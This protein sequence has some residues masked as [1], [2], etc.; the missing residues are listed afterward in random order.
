LRL[1]PKELGGLIDR[2][3]RRRWGWLCETLKHD[4]HRPH[5]D[6][7]D[8]LG[9]QDEPDERFAHRP[10]SF[11]EH[12]G[13]RGESIGNSGDVFRYVL[14]KI[15]Y[16][17]EEVVLATGEFPRKRETRGVGDTVDLAVLP[18]ARMD[19]AAGVRFWKIV[20]QVPTP[21]EGMKF[22]C[23]PLPPE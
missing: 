15:G 16:E 9:W 8:R 10:S 2:Q 1:A 18:G 3:I 6:C 14:V 4:L 22:V 7:L 23:E 11:S 12:S 5:R 21:D 13:S 20:R 19:D 17:G